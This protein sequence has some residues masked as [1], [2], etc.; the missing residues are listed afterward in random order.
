MLS[1]TSRALSTPHQTGSDR[2]GRPLADRE[3]RSRLLRRPPPRADVPHPHEPLHDHPPALAHDR[4]LRVHRRRGPGRLRGSPVHHRS[5][6]PEVRDRVPAALVSPS[7]PPLPPGTASLTQCR[8]FQP[9]KLTTSTMTQRTMPRRRV[10]AYAGPDASRRAAVAEDAQRGLD[11]VHAYRAVGGHPAGPV[12]AHVGPW[13]RT[14]S[15]V[16]GTREPAGARERTAAAGLPQKQEACGQGRGHASVDRNL[17]GGSARTD[18]EHWGRGSHTDPSCLHYCSPI[19]AEVSRLG[20][21]GS[22]GTEGCRFGR[23]LCA[24]RCSLAD[25]EFC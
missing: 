20:L 10:H 11:D 16:R 8:Y 24:L 17:R 22:L 2:L 18:T 1:L 13:S 14:A 5:S 12:R 25:F 3:C 19:A 9:L 4:L 23:V 7:L 21:F 15:T 6:G